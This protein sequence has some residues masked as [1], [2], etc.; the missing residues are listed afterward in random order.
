MRQRQF[1]SLLSLVA[2]VHHASLA[3]ALPPVCADACEKSLQLVRFT[4]VEAGASVPDQK[5][6]SELYQKSL[7]LCLD[8]HCGQADVSRELSGLNDTCSGSLPPWSII[9]DY[10]DDAIERIERIESKVLPPWVNPRGKVILP[11][12]E[13]YALWEGTLVGHFFEVVAV[14]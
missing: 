11:S 1:G 3:L 7:F 6:R 13:F 9:S 2:A 8:L 12:D 14:P 5:C 4:D 10:T